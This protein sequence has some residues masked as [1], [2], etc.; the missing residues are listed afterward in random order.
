MNTTSPRWGIPKKIALLSVILIPLAILA[1]RFG[2][3]GFPIAGGMLVIGVISGLVLFIASIIAIFRHR[4]DNEGNESQSNRWSTLRRGSFAPL[5]ILAFLGT[6]GS[7]GKLPIIHDIT[8]DTDNVPTFSHAPSLRDSYS[9]SLEIDTTVI[10]AQ[11]AGYPELETL[12]S[13]LPAEAAFIRA[14]KIALELG[15][16]IYYQDPANGIIEAYEKTPMWGFIDDIV[17][18]LSETP[19]GTAIDLR[20]ASRVGGGDLGANAARI[21][22]FY[23]AFSAQ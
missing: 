5:A 10:A 13:T 15:W 2:I 12:N 21:K 19:S 6:A 4:N 11:Q 22:A 9:N 3:V 18:R 1:H 17:I 20:S 16:V 7:A 14:E 23:S 8:T